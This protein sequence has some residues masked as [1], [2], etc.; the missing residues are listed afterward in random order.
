VF[1]GTCGEVNVIPIIMSYSREIRA[2]GNQ[3]SQI[4]P[5]IG[6]TEDSKNL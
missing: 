5:M 2:S 3:L 6:G 4:K 1:K